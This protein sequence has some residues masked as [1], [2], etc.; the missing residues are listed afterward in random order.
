MKWHAKLK[1]EKDC[2]TILIE[3]KTLNKRGKIIHWNAKKIFRLLRKK[4]H[5]AFNFNICSCYKEPSP[6]RQLKGNN[7]II[8][9][10]DIDG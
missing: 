4:G 10:R 8:I 3:T 2:E 9:I 6:L 5:N 7:S 1:H